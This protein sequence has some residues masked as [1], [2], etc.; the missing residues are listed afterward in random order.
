VG[1]TD[2]SPAPG[3]TLPG[4][5]DASAAYRSMG[6][7]VGGGA[8]PFVASVRYLAGPT[9]DS[10]LALF[11]LSLTNQTLTFQHHGNE[12]VAGYHVEATFHTD[13]TG[14]APVR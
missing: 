7:L 6:S 13:N 2:K 14:T 4:L 9:P 11:S 3:T 8:L 12:F 5:F 1:Q 10:T